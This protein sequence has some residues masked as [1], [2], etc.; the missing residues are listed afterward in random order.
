VRRDPPLTQPSVIEPPLSPIRALNDLSL[1]QRCVAGD[2]S[3]QREVF[4]REVRRVHAALYRILGSNAFMD[5]LMQEAFLEVFRSL[6]SF[7]GEASLSTWVDRC[8]VRVAY[9]QLSKKRRRFPQLELVPDVP[10]ADPN[11]EERAMAREAARHL[12]AELDRIEPNHRVAFALHAIEGRPIEEVAK[13]MEASV[14][15][16]K[17]RI[18]RARLALEKRARRDPLL[19]RFLELEGGARSQGGGAEA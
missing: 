18:R 5:D 13:V 10:D 3:A 2:R 1:A 11:A 9:A 12:Y 15:A 8:T 16:T 14:A 4:D 19:A 7:R 6:K 17:S